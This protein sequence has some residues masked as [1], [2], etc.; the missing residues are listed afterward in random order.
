M[1]DRS[2]GAKVYTRA[3]FNYRHAFQKA[4]EAAS[5]V[6]V[7]L[8]RKRLISLLEALDRICPDS[9]GEFPVFLE[10]T[11][12]GDVLMKAQGH[13]GQRVLGFMKAY[14]GGEGAWMEPDAWERGMMNDPGVNPEAA[15]KRKP[16][17]RAP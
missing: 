13:H 10:F 17:R 12:A 3:Y 6:R 7:V 15:P 1:R 14:Q 2:I 9:S 8:N 5:R 11:N 16:A 4:N